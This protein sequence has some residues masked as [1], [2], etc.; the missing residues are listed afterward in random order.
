M[1][2]INVLG[3]VLEWLSKPGDDFCYDIFSCA[4]EALPV[5]VFYTSMCSMLDNDLLVLADIWNTIVSVAEELWPRNCSLSF[6]KV[7]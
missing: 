7:S 6:L 4:W 1:K 5:F 2:P 3:L